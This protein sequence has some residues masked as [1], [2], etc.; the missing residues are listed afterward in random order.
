M[1]EDGQELLQY[2]YD[3]Y[4]RNYGVAVHMHQCQDM[5][6]LL[7]CDTDAELDS[8][9]PCTHCNEPFLNY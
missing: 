5:P 2:L 3:N 8:A 1:S 6:M 7:L 4:C 9:S